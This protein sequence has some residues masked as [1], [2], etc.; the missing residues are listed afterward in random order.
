M[1]FQSDFLMAKTSTYMYFPI[2]VITNPVYF[3]ITQLVF[4]I[5]YI[6]VQAPDSIEDFK[7]NASFR[8]GEAKFWDYYNMVWSYQINCMIFL[9]NMDT[10]MVNRELYY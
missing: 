6:C 9:G 1:L 8:D 3:Q 5:N 10:I 4:L 2:F 7:W